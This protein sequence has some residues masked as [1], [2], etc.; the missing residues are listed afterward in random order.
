MKTLWSD[1]GSNHDRSCR[2]FMTNLYLPLL[3]LGLGLSHLWKTNARH[4]INFILDKTGN[5]D[6]AGNVVDSVLTVRHG[7]MAEW[8]KALVLGTSHFGG[9][10]SNP[11][12][13]KRVFGQFGTKNFVT[14]TTCDISWSRQSGWPSGL[15]RC[16]QVAVYLCRRGFE[17][18]FWQRPI[19]SIDIDISS[20]YVPEIYRWYTVRSQND[21]KSC[22]T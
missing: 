22:R 5:A 20:I 21:H 11:T 14:M 8:S 2:G 16:V 6:N 13:I 17:S 15:R 7:R 10:G 3:G 18:H 19:L 1:P 4:K 12:T 9:V